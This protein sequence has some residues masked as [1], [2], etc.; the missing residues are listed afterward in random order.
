VNSRCS[1]VEGVAGDENGI[2]CRGTIV[3]WSSDE[4][5][6]TEELRE[7][8]IGGRVLHPQSDLH[9]LL[10]NTRSPGPF[11]PSRVTTTG[12]HELSWDIAYSASPTALSA[13]ARSA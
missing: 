1:P 2:A 6:V 13:S 5:V 9:V 4:I 10:R 11:H 3:A 8:H 12:R 7:I